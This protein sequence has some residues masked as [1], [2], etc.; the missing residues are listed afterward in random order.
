MSW[1]VKPE[2]YLNCNRV[3][4]WVQR[5]I[6]NCRHK[7]KDRCR[8]G[9]TYQE[10]VDAETAIIKEAQQQ[11]FNVEY[12]AIQHQQPIPKNSTLLTLQLIMDEERL[13]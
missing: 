11:A 5:F 4:R 10:I 2:R 7:S 3:V 6:E 8:E 13:L 9:I 1:Q 12:T